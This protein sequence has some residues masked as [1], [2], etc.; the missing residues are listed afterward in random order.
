M[1]QTVPIP[2]PMQSNSIAKLA[3]AFAKAQG[4][5]RTPTMNRLAKIKN[6]QGTLLYE[7]PYA[8]L[9]ECIDC[10]RGPLSENGLSFIQS[11]QERGG[12]WFLV[13][14]LIHESGETKE[15]ILPLNVNQANQ[16]LGGTL[17]YLKRYQLSAFFG[18]AADA[19]DDGNATGN[20]QAEFEGKDKG[21]GKQNNG[22]AGGPA[23]ANQGKQNPSQT[24]TMPGSGAA[25]KREIAQKAL[26]DAEKQKSAPLPLATQE[27]IDSME[28]ISSGLRIDPQQ[29]IDL[30]KA[31]GGDAAQLKSWIV[32]DITEFL[33][34]LVG[35]DDLSPLMMQQIKKVNERREMAA[36]KNKPAGDA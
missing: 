24:Q 4:K 32:K 12:K 18:L 21:R 16:Q 3:T 27:E 33:S 10:V 8:D 14:E 22:S 20:N 13:L 7:N 31:Y 29:M 2:T 35:E 15:T 11:T 36:R 19:D 28:S 26:D 17:T 6:A 5:F 34:G 30:I 9:Q 23:K 25:S 1:D